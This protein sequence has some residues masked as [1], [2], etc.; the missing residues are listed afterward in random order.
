MIIDKPG[1][2][3][4]PFDDYLADPVP[5]GSLSSTGA[6]KL[7]EP[8]GPAKFRWDRD[9]PGERVTDAFDLG[10]AAHHSVLG[11][12]DDRVVVCDFKDWR[13]KAAQEMAAEA[14]E[15]GKTPI[16]TKT[17][18]TVDDMAAAIRSHRTAA[19]LLRAASGRPEQSLFWRDPET[20]LWCRA[21]VDW[22]R[23]QVPDRRFLCVDYKSCAKADEISFGKA[24]AE[25][26]YHQ[27]DDWYRAGIRALGIDDDP[28]FLFVAQEKT[29]PYLVNVIELDAP[30]K[31]IGRNLNRIAIGT[32]LECT[33][34]GRWP[35]YGDEVRQ[36]SLPAYYLRN[37]DEQPE[38]S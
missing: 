30:A 20:G 19:A 25:Y 7:I 12:L 9:H 18:E 13:T 16:L 17:A 23:H 15:A 37:H 36:V 27:Q 22:F 10:V 35:G 11:D 2:Y 34:S 31:T 6:K 38:A 5:G 21:R 29:P 1:I 33:R 8:A 24:A 14:R 32:Y 4:L 26:G 3:D 28:A